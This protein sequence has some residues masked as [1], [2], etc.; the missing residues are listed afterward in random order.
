MEYDLLL[1]QLKLNEIALIHRK[2]G[3]DL[4]RQHDA[5]LAANLPFDDFPSAD[6]TRVRAQH[7]SPQSRG[8]RGL[9]GS[10]RTTQNRQNAQNW[11]VDWS[12]RKE[13]KRAR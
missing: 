4:G 6:T 11:R 5:V 7:P 10:R 9:A 12:N 2:E 3:H 13:V 8:R 1:T